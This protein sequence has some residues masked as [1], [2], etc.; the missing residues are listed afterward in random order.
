M[1]GWG[2]RHRSTALL[3]PTA[4]VHTVTLK[5]TSQHVFILQLPSFGFFFSWLWPCHGNVNHTVL[6]GTQGRFLDFSSRDREVPGTFLIGQNAAKSTLA[7]G[8]VYQLIRNISVINRCVMIL[9]IHSSDHQ[10]GSLN[11]TRLWALSTGHECL[12]YRPIL[13]L[14][15]KRLTKTETEAAHTALSL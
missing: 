4:V 6:K 13:C 7:Y 10:F 14:V 11:A 15:S 5:M 1:W 12:T 9:Q 3:E 2:Q 8:I